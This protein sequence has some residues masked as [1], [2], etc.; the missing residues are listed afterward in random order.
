MKKHNTNRKFRRWFGALTAAALSFMMLPLQGTAGWEDAKE[1]VSNHPITF[2]DVNDDGEVTVIDLII[3]QGVLHGHDNVTILAPWNA[4]INDDGA[5]DVFDLALAKRIVLNGALPS[6]PTQPTEPTEPTDPPEQPVITEG[7]LYKMAGAVD[8]YAQITA[9]QTVLP[10]GWKLSMESSWNGNY[11]ATWPGAELVTITS[12][13]GKAWIR[14]QS[15]H[16]FTQD[17]LYLRSGASTADNTIYADYV[18]AD[19]YIQ[20]VV[21]S[22]FSDAELKKEYAEHPDTLEAMQE[23]TKYWAQYSYNTITFGGVYLMG[24]EDMQSS[25]SRRQYRLGSAYAEFSC[26]VNMYQ[27]ALAGS[28]LPSV[29]TTH[30]IIWW[31]PYTIMYYA[32]D[33]AAFEQYFTDYEVITGNSCFTRQFYAMNEYVAARREYIELAARTESLNEWMTGVSAN[34]FNDNYSSETS[35]SAQ[36]QIFQAWDDYIKDENS[37]TLSDGSTLRLPNSVEAIAQSGDTL[38][39]GTETGVPS[40]FDLLQPN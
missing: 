13:D 39:V 15:P 3:L 16:Q 27:Y 21:Q 9:F 6:D 5:V 17:L 31:V 10:E 24:V 8:P 12:P 36:E 11:S 23:Q 26:A 14:I 1:I 40:G 19:K 35:L 32:E 7:R 38:Y 33:Q 28:S 30:K 29:I 37:Y 34:F 4:D 22:S 2:G 20:T 25:M 18:D